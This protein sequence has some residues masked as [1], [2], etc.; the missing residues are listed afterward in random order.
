M[1]GIDLSAAQRGQ[2]RAIAVGILLDVLLL[3]P[4][5]ASAIATG[6]ISILAELLRGAL[7]LITE[8]L[9]LYTL[10]RI[11]RGQLGNFDYGLGKTERAI[12]GLVGVLLV[13]AAGFVIFRLVTPDD[14]AEAPRTVG[15]LAMLAVG[16]NFLA[17]AGPLYALWRSARGDLTVT[18]LAQLQA[19]FAKTIASATVVVCVAIDLFAANRTIGHAADIVGGA[20]GAAFMIVIGVRLVREA[21]PDLVDRALDE[22]VQM[23]VTQALARFYHDYDDLDGVRTRRA[24][25]VAH[26]EIA[27]RFAPQKTMA[28]VGRVLDA[29]AGA[30]KEAIPD[31]DVVVVARPARGPQAAG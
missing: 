23:T 22:S 17:N 7:L 24:G 2:E 31:A 29:M 4:Y 12:S 15:V 9:G 10:R 27:V 26:I 19:R 1:A 3:A 8:M 30:L 21:L 18:V 28:E 25:N 20:I 5:T 6:S 16:A 13:A 11:N 14:A